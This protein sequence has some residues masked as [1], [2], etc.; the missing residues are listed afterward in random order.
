MTV[1]H[2]LSQLFCTGLNYIII[3]ESSG[4]WPMY[5]YLVGMK[6]EDIT[7]HAE[8]PGSSTTSP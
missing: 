6:P 8:P 7:F 1:E 5:W 3:V 4:R 2:V